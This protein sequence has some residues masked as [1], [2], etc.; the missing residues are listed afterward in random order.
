[1]MT[2]WSNIKFKIQL[3]AFT[4]NGLSDKIVDVIKSVGQPS[5]IKYGQ[6]RGDITVWETATLIYGKEEKYEAE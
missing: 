4:K 1:M 6:R 3:E 2:D 5:S